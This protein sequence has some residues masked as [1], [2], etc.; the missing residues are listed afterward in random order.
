MLCQPGDEQG[1][2][3]GAPAVGGVGLVL[4]A[5]VVAGLVVE[6]AVAQGGSGGGSG[7]GGAGGGD[8]VHYRLT[9]VVG[10]AVAAFLAVGVGGFG[11]VER[12]EDR[13][14]DHA[15]LAVGGHGAVA[16]I[17]VQR[18]GEAACVADHALAECQAEVSD[19]PEDG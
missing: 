13:G 11:E 14:A 2:V 12:V 19:Y 8:G 7:G 10:E 18:P 15:W 4:I 6:G 16:G 17:Q 9:E 1:E 5:G 3:R